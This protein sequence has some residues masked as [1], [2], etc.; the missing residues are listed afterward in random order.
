MSYLP[1]V[2]SKSFW[3]AWSLFFD[4]LPRIMIALLIY[5]VAF[6]LLWHQHRYDE[7]TRRVRTSIEAAL[8]TIICFVLTWIAHFAL[9]TPSR[10]LNEARKQIPTNDLRATVFPYNYDWSKGELYSSVHFVNN[11]PTRRTVSGVKMFY[12]DKYDKGTYSLTDSNRAEFFLD[13]HPAYVEPHSSADVTYKYKVGDDLVKIPGR[14]F[15]LNFTIM[16]DDGMLHFSAIEALMVTD[17]GW[18]IGNPK[19]Q[20]ISLDAGN[21]IVMPPEARQ[22]IPQDSKHGR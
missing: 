4:P 13:D 11:G 16:N 6:I 10:L 8:V 3:D 20:N 12:R 1:E 18:L 15:G 5:I 22:S 21:F 17:R 9:F 7:A 2:L 19:M 14:V